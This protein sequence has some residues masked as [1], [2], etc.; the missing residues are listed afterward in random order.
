MRENLLFF[1]V[2]MNENVIIVNIFSLFDHALLIMCHL[3]PF[4]ST[5]LVLSASG[6]LPPVGPQSG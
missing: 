4:Q 5:W 1:T 3:S 6:R 2:R